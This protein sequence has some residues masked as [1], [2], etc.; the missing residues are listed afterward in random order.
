MDV[1]PS[2]EDGFRLELVPKT[3]YDL[4]LSL[5]YE[6]PSPKFSRACPG[7]ISYRLKLLQV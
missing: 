1:L 6:P 7:Q 5:R 3:D 2:L 4:Q